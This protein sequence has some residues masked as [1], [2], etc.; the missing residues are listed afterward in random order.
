MSNIFD[1]LGGY[2][3]ENTEEE[4][5]KV[6][7]KT[8]TKKESKTKTPKEKEIGLPVT[9]VSGYFPDFTIQVSPARK[10][11]KKSDILKEFAAYVDYPEGL[12]V[13]E[14]GT[15]NENYYACFK[16]IGV[17]KGTIS[18]NENSCLKLNGM[19]YDLS[20]VK[21]DVTCTVDISEVQKLVVSQTP[22]FEKEEYVKIL[23]EGDF[24][25]PVPKL[26]TSKGKDLSFPV[27]VFV[28][29]GGR[30]EITKEE[31]QEF[32]RRDK[33]KNMKKDAADVALEDV[34][35]PSENI[36]KSIILD[37]LPMFKDHMNLGYNE[38]GKC[39]VVSMERKKVAPEGPKKV[40]IPTDVVVSLI[41]TRIQLTPE[42]FDGATEV[43]EDAIIELL[44]KTYP[45]YSKERTTLEYRKKEKLVIP[46]LKGSTK[47]AELMPL[48][49]DDNEIREAIGD[50][51]EYYLFKSK[52]GDSEYRNENIPG[53]AGFSIEMNGGGT[54]TAWLHIPK[55]PF[56][57]YV[58]AKEFFSYVSCIYHTEAALQLFYDKIE[59]EYFF[60]CPKQKVAYSYLQMERNEELELNP[61]KVLVM[62]LHSHGEI[63]SSFSL[64]DDSDEKGTRFYG[65]FYNYRASEPSFDLRAGCGGNFLAIEREDI[66]DVSDEPYDA[67]YDFSDWISKLEV[68]S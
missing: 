4:N 35:K 67:K 5:K 27:R 50:G 40:Y 34:E 32:V 56:W 45:E 51:T 58:V 1:L 52:L 44:R 24:M 25:V 21:T 30:F 63:N 53:F 41:F 15:S 17:E 36:I 59:N 43:E 46:H 8:K 10:T 61:D 9:V 62:D 54:G 65:V 22:F 31:Y 13:L 28:M 19:E 33:A 20:A 11:I 12:F 7:K 14:D 6:E 2:S 39:F 66:F 38:T 16:G 26:P 3:V 55:I 64:I 60:Y 29:M 42:M 57:A 47:G 49:T 23:R 68:I 37:K 48:L 18:L